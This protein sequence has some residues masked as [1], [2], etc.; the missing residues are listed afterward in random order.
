MKV[1]IVLGLVFYSGC[2]CAQAVPE[3]PSQI[4][5]TTGS[6]TVKV[7]DWRYEQIKGTP[8][9][10]KDFLIGKIQFAK[11]QQEKTM[12]LSYD[13][14]NDQVLVK[15][16]TGAA[17]FAIRK[18]VV[19]RFVIPYEGQSYEFVRLSHE[20]NIGYYLRLINGKISL[21][22]KVSKIIHRPKS[23]GDHYS[24]NSSDEF[25]T[26]NQYYIQQGDNSLRELQKSKKSI[27]AAFPE[28]EDAVSAILKKNKV[29]FNSY[30]KMAKV[31]SE[32]EK[33]F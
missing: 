25:L 12:L 33:L 18:D 2:L 1:A 4:P 9:F 17:A 11:E 21:F 32:I 8:T 29:D 23:D 16:D 5:F 28:H 27:E 14:F 26:R 30:I 3:I 20:G 15:R 31:F 7:F 19:D 22:C 13:A 6:N 24:V 10:L